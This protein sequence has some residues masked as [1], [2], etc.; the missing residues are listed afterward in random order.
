MATTALIPYVMAVFPAMMALSASTDLLTMTIP[1][2]IPA[3]L[4]VGYIVAA[5]ALGLPP[6]E[7]LFDLSCGLVVLAASFFLFA[8]GWMGGGDAKFAAA[9]ALWIGWS[10][11]LDY[12][13]VASILGGVLTLGILFARAVPLPD[14]LARRR[15]IARLHESGAGVPYGIALALAGFAEFSQTRIWAASA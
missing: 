9:T 4:G 8:R 15:W 5:A 11:I 7:I 6:S 14:V 12:A 2:V 13:V 10:S 3:T 1:N